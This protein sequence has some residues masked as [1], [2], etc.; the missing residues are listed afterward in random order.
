M[1][2]YLLNIRLDQKIIELISN[3]DEYNDYF[4]QCKDELLLAKSTKLT[5][6]WVNFLNLLT[7]NKRKLKNYTGTKELIRSFEK[8]DCLNKFPI[9]GASMQEKMEKGIKTRR[10]FDESAKLLSNYLPTYDPFHIIIRDILD[11]VLSKNELN[12]IVKISTFQDY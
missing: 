2:K 9:Y 3:Q 1:L 8:S 10:W 12:Y 7:D 4:E 11:T 6:S 5:N